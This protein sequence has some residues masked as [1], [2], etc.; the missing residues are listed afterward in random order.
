MLILQ[1]AAPHHHHTLLH[2]NDDI[3]FGCCC[4][5]G[6]HSKVRHTYINHR[7]GRGLV[8]GSLCQVAKTF[9]LKVE[10]PF[11]VE[12]HLFTKQRQAGGERL[13]LDCRKKK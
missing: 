13:I 8:D 7:S 12:N 3:R 6:S 4:I 5:Q 9:Q 1:N 11:K 10:N 2:P